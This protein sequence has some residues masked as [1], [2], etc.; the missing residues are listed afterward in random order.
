M[1]DFIKLILG[2][3]LGVFFAYFST[4]ILESR[5]KHSEQIIS[6]NLALI[7]L[8]NQYNEFLVFRKGFREDMARPGFDD[9][10]PLWSFARPIFITFGDYDF[11]FKSIGFILNSTQ[12][13]KVFEQI[14]LV[15]T[16]HRDLIKLIKTYTETAE[17]FQ[18][19]IDQAEIVI[20]EDFWTQVELSVGKSITS[21]LALVVVGAAL[22]TERNEILYQQ[23]FNNLK[24]ALESH[25]NNHEKFQHQKYLNCFLQLKPE[26]VS[27]IT[28]HA[29][30][31]PFAYES[32]PQLPVQ[33][34]N[35]VAKI[36]EYSNY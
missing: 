23:A 24:A 34:S 6:A 36:P 10:A 16:S 9:A 13:S 31:A 33:L 32:L 17:Y 29:V 7:T 18:K 12:Y 8:K 2:P 25:L 5:R 26:N 11:D 14:E 27:L 21:L 30:E 20:E 4:R 1:F 28:L 19:K 22:R 15:Q 3:F 35:E